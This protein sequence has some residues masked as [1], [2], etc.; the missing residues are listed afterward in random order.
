MDDRERLADEIMGFLARHARRSPE[1][2]PETDP[3][4]EAFTGP[5][6]ATLFQAAACLRSGDEVPMPWSEWG[7]GCYASMRD[8]GARAWHDRL[9]SA[10]RKYAPHQPPAVRNS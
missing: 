2:D 3:P 1:H 4:E 10:V 9:V 5:D 7:S 6:P 8:D